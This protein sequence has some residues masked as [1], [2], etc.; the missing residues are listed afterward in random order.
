MTLVVDRGSLVETGEQRVV[1]DTIRKRRYQA[2]MLAVGDD[3]GRHAGA[4]ACAPSRRRFSIY[5][6]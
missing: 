2:A 3:I 5:M 4:I 6:H 1:P